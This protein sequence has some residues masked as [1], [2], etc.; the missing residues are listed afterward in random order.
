[1]PGILLTAGGVFDPMV[2]E[3]KEMHYQ[4]RAPFVL[5]DTVTREAFGIEATPFAES[6]RENLA[7]AR[8]EIDAKA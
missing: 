5:D 2:R 3:F 7:F 6:L 4:F 1:M 8:A